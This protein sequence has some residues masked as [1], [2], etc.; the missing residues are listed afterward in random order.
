MG[1]GSS[2]SFSNKNAVRMFRDN[3]NELIKSDPLFKVDKDGYFGRP[4]KNSRVDVREIESDNR[5]RTAKSFFEK[6]TA[7]LGDK[8]DI[9]D[10][11]KKI[12]TV[13]NINDEI[14]ITYRP[15]SSS[16]NASPAVNVNSKQT[17]LPVQNQKVHFINK[18]ED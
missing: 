1:G 18:G 7:G 2:N 16:P 6:I 8:E 3:L 14:Y 11:G 17:S 13:V 5:L 9:F 15:I 12:G 4:G 10:K